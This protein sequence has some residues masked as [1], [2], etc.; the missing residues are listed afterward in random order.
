MLDLGC[1]AG[2]IGA[3]IKQQYPQVELTMADIHALALASSQRTLVENQLE[4]EVIASDVFSNVT[5][6]FDLII[7]NPPFTMALTRLIV[8]SV[9]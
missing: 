4:A 8:L 9:N 6:K 7:S 1:G 3:Y 5:G 2:V